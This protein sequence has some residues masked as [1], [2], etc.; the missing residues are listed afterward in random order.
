MTLGRARDRATHQS[1]YCVVNINQSQSDITLLGF[2]G[3]IESIRGSL[4]NLIRRAFSAIKQS[5][6]QLWQRTGFLIYVQ[7]KSKIEEETHGP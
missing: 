3:K 5:S 1:G 6:K 2:L 4:R 7:D